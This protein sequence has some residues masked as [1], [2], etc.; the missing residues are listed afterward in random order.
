MID[1]A[2]QP[3]CEDVSPAVLGLGG[4][5]ILDIDECVCVY[6]RITIFTAWEIL[7][8]NQLDN[9]QLEALCV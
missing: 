8:W 9:S 7:L 2:K 6:C 1:W 3:R 5:Q 4:I